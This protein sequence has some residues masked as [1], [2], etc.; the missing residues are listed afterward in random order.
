MI[1]LITLNLLPIALPIERKEEYFAKGYLTFAVKRF[2]HGKNAN[3]APPSAKIDLEISRVSENVIF[4][5]LT[6]LSTRT[7]ATAWNPSLTANSRKGTKLQ[8]G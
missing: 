1:S 8:V 7:T 2:I 6:I 5:R 3:Q 4:R